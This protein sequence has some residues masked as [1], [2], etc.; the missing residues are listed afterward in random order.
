MTETTNYDMNQQEPSKV[1]SALNFGA[2]LGLV[3]LVINLSSYV[4]ELVENKLFTFLT[5]GI[6]IGGIVYGIKKY[7]DGVLK[8]FISYGSALG[9]GVLISLFAS[10]ISSFASYLYLKFVDDSILLSLLEKAEIEMIEQ[11]Q[12]EQAIEIGMK[13][14]EAI[15][16]PMGMFL[17]GILATTFMGLII[18]L[19]AAAFLKNDPDSFENS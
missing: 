11:G 14:S 6:I 18:S 1:K 16:S 4:F 2:I 15:Y 3:L 8:G 19:I 10:I 7:R 17:L 5:W 9:Y 12:P 13:V